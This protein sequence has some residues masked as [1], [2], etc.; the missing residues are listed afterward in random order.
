MITIAS[1]ADDHLPD[2]TLQE[3]AGVAYWKYAA[4]FGLVFASL[5]LQ[6]L[7]VF[8]I[9]KYLQ[10]LAA[11]T[12]RPY[13]VS[14]VSRLGRPIGGFAMAL[15]F[16]FGVPPLDLPEKVDQVLFVATEALAAFSA[17]WAGYRLIDV[18]GDFMA[19]KAAKTESRLDDQLVP[20]VT[21]TLKVFVAIVGGIFVLQNLEVNVG[22]LLAGLGLGGLAFAL[23]AKDTVANFFGSVMIFVDKPFQIGDW[24]VISGTE[25]VVEEVGFRTTRVRTFYNSLVTVPNSTVVGAMVDNYGARQYRRYSTTLG[26]CYDTPADKVQAFCEGV[27]AI[28]QAHPGMRKDYYLVEFKQ[29]G[30]TSF[31]IMVYCFMI[32]KNWNEEMRT[33]TQINLEIVRL[34]EALGVSFAFPTQT[35]HVETMARPGEARRSHGG[36]D[37]PAE[38]IDIV[39]GFGP[40]G[41]LGRP[42][43][44]RL[45]R[46]W[47]CGTARHGGDGDG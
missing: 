16:Y 8:V 6:R 26:L 9:R 20:L 46:G 36:P 22:S 41:Q 31:D 45:T 18:L 43:G 33:R 30:A 14:A 47:D 21:K 19:S 12:E 40:G 2:W 28:L 39:N 3:A 44:A 37:T 34:A 13:L 5:T 11:H 25:G 10:R 7:V 29:F 42:A 32:A 15:V 35:I 1:W 27:R 4:L 23:A 38:L 17:V 24:V